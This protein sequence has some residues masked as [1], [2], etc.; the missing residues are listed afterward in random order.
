[1]NFYKHQRSRAFTDL[2]PRPLRFST[3]EIYSKT[4]GLIETILH[5]EP[6]WGWEIK[7]RSWDQGHM[8]KMSTM[9][10]CGKKGLKFFISVV[11][12]WLEFTK[13]QNC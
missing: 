5:I 9:P 8:T 6:R 11:Q 12:E 1:M 4:A 3:F 10:I 13:N 7:L 2:G